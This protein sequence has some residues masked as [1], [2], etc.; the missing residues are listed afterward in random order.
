[1]ERHPI[2]HL[3]LD[4]DAAFSDLQDKMDKVIH[5]A[6]DFTIAALERGMESG[7]PSLVLRIDLPDGRVV[8]QETS[9]RLFLA[10]AAAIRGR[11]GDPE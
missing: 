7:R 3:R 2:I 6:G 11:F 1:M 10:A 4:G 8:M 9:V 5:L